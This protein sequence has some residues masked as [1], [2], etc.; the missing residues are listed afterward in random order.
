[1]GSLDGG[2]TPVYGF[3]ID[4]V[5]REVRFIDCLGWAIYV[6]IESRYVVSTWLSTV[7]IFLLTTRTC[8]LL[9]S[10]KFLSTKGIDRFYLLQLRESLSTQF[11]EGTCSVDL[12]VPIHRTDAS[13]YA[14]ITA[15]TFWD[16]RTRLLLELIL[17]LQK[18]TAKLGLSN[19]LIDSFC[20]SMD[21]LNVEL[22]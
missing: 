16:F 19:R 7:R 6:A 12:M 15:Q 3:D 20:R 17:L 10:Q 8:H 4:G 13:T 18:A 5:R 22:L 21:P 1:L 14:P 2:R 11:C 9:V